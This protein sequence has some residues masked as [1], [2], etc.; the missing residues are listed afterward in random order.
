MWKSAPAQTLRDLN[1]I[2]IEGGKFSAYLKGKVSRGGR[3][4]R[5]G[6]GGGVR[7][8]DRNRNSVPLRTARLAQLCSDYGAPRFSG[9]SCALYLSWL[10]R[11]PVMRMIADVHNFQ[12]PFLCQLSKSVPNILW[13]VGS[14]FHNQPLQV[15]RS[16]PAV[17]IAKVSFQSFFEGHIFL[18]IHTAFWQRV[19]NH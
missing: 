16:N 9:Q 8:P 4:L 2:Y 15:A 1:V 14:L 6:P 3:Q 17:V 10:L 7:T 18:K 12:P 11:G 13:S 5:R 19:Q